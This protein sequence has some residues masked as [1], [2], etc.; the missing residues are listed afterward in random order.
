MFYKHSSLKWLKRF[1][2]NSLPMV[3]NCTTDRIF[4][5]VFAESEINFSLLQSLVI[6]SSAN[7]RL[8]LLSV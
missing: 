4:L 7:H 1:Q 6:L 2:T 3:R 5:F 8:T